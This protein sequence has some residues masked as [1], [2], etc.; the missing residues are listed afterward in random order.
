MPEGPARVEKKRI[1]KKEDKIGPE[2]A[3]GVSWYHC[4][5][6][7]EGGVGKCAAA[8]YGTRDIWRHVRRKYH[9]GHD[10][11]KASG[12]PEGVKLCAGAGCQLCPEKSGDQGKS[13]RKQAKKCSK[14]RLFPAI[15]PN[16]CTHLHSFSPIAGFWTLFLQWPRPYP[17]HD[18]RQANMVTLSRP[19]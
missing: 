1:V 12:I 10:W 14:S 17:F 5:L 8:K 15:G 19:S 13:M 16:G 3:A 18:A 2:G 11:K 9:K 7:R 6:E 4:C